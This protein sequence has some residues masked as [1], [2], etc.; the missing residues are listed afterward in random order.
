MVLFDRSWYNRAGVERVMGFCRE[1]DVTRFFAETPVLEGQLVRDGI[2]LIKLYLSISRETQLK[3]FHTRYHDPLKRWKLTEIDFAAIGKWDDYSRAQDE[4]FER[5][6]TEHAPWTVV[7]ANDKLRAR[8][9]VIRHVLWSCDYEGKD[10]KAV[11]RPDPQIVG[12]G[13]EFFAG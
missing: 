1:E 4:M 7:R 12:S 3:R 13:K 10:R 8:L 6:H 5:T 2:K 9:G 11:G